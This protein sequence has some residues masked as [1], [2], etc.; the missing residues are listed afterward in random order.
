MVLPIALTPF[1]CLDEMNHAINPRRPIKRTQATA[2]P[3]M[4]PLLDF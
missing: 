2:R 1:L 3:T 4:A